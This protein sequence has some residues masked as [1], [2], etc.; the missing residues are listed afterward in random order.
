MFLKVCTIIDLIELDSYALIY[1][2]YEN[3]EQKVINMFL[4]NPHI[5][6]FTF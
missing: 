5:Q 3:Y 1:F 2:K 6:R 4:V